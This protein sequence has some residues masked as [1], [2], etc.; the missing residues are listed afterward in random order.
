EVV[1]INVSRQSETGTVNDWS[2]VGSA[3]ERLTVEG[4]RVVAVRMVVFGRASDRSEVHERER[5]EGSEL[6]RRRIMVKRNIFAW[7]LISTFDSV[8]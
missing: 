8:D 6:R 7:G 2:Q 5:V 3:D 1:I 4:A